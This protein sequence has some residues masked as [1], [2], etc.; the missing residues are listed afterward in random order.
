[1]TRKISATI[2]VVALLIILLASLASSITTISD[3]DITTTGSININ[4][5]TF[6]HTENTNTSLRFTLQ[7]L[8]AGTNATTIISALNDV[9]G[10]LSIGVG[11]SNFLLG[12]TDY[13]NITALFS[14]AR[15]E[16]VFA[17]F[18]NQMFSWLYNPQDDNDPANLIKL[19]RLDER[20]LDVTGNITG[21]QIYGE[22]YFHNDT[23]GNVAA[24]TEDVWTNVTAFDQP[25]N[26]QSLNGFTYSSNTLTAQVA[27]LYLTNF[28]ITFTGTARNK[29]HITPGIN[30][31]IQ[32]NLETHDMIST[33]MDI[34]STSGTGFLQ[35]AVGDEI[36]LLIM[37]E[38]SDGDATINSAN[39]NLVRIGS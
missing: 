5:N 30:G 36:T 19:M 21:N 1:M 25:H 3:T 39:I 18:Y 28:K 24:L 32:F 16:M 2:I 12:N 26:G 15:G 8:N 11:S 6:S 4:D 27:G 10:S 22:M 38:D 23:A 31:T 33:A 9:G 20:G 17:N 35:V 37:N 13:S 7:N 34:L 14:K 29:Y